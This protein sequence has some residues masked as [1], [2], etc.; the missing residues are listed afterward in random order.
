MIPTKPLASQEHTT[1]KKLPLSR[2]RQ[3]NKLAPPPAERCHAVKIDR[4]CLSWRREK[5]SPPPPLP[6]KTSQA[7][8]SFNSSVSSGATNST[9]AAAAP[10]PAAKQL[11]MY[12]SFIPHDLLGDER[13]VI[14]G[15]S[16]GKHRGILK[17]GVKPKKPKTQSGHDMNLSP[18]AKCFFPTPSRDVTV[19]PVVNR[20][21]ILGGGRCLSGAPSS[22]DTESL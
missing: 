15:S 18:L 6:P 12:L 11:T 7:L 3:T 1:T 19:S 21:V 4:W 8:S 5:R 10:P 9:A 14:C 13:D 16:R 22:R 2:K 17:V 20:L